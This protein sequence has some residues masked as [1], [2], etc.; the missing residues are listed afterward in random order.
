MQALYRL[1]TTP[2]QPSRNAYLTTFAAQTETA[3]ANQLRINGRVPSGVY[4]AQS[5]DALCADMK[6]FRSPISTLE[7]YYPKAKLSV[8]GAMNGVTSLVIQQ[9]PLS[10]VQAAFM[11]SGDSRAFHRQSVQCRPRSSDRRDHRADRDALHQRNG[12]GAVALP[13]F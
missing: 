12:E 4:V 6:A 8:L 1:M 2:S 13:R 5:V 10:S 3:I 9:C 7:R 11:T